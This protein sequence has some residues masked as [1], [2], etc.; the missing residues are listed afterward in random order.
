M[1]DLAREVGVLGSSLYSHITSKEDLLVEIV[2][3]GAA[4][5]QAVADR[6]TAAGGSGAERVAALIAGHIDVVL[7]HLDEARTFLYEAGALDERHRHKVIAAR[8]RYE[9]VFRGAIAAGV[10]DG[11]FRP[12]IDPKLAAIMILSILNAVE[13]WYR[14]KG[15]LNRRELSSQV[16]E[17][18]LRGIGSPTSRIAGAAATAQAF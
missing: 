7:D 4:L 8:D 11:S 15:S 9:A 10:A 5:F 14:P 2:E 12:G 16:H 18:A 13:R 3:N 1:R 17:F 6:A